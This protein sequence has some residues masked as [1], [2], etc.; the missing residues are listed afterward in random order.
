[1]SDRADFP[2][3][4]I[5]EAARRLKALRQEAGLS[6]SAVAR[7]LGHRHPSRYQHYE[8]RF[9]RTYLPV[10]LAE[11]LAPL[12]AERGVS[13]DA[14]RALAGLPPI[15]ERLE[16]MPLRSQ[17]ARK[18]LPV[19]GGAMGGDAGYFCNDGTAKDYA[20]RPPSL[21]GVADAFAVLVYGDSMEPRYM[22]GEIV[23]VDPGRPL[24]SGCFVIVEL[25]DGRGM[26][27]QFLRQDGRGVVLRQFRPER[28]LRIERKRIVRMAR[29][30]GSAER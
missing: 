6:M 26:I 11:R 13:A 14:V 3:G 24:T 16:R 29:I 30:V 10:E 19:L 27:K 1:M 21:T 17:M 7:H 8:D 22:R 23:H 18:D 2:P 12:F 5:S 9:R 28:E 4:G 20:L 25:V 15:V